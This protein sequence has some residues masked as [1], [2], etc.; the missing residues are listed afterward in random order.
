MPTLPIFDP[1]AFNNDFQPGEEAKEKAFRERW[2]GNL[3]R[4][5]EQTLLND[6]WSS[7]YQPALRDY[8]NPL[9]TD[10]PIAT[11]APITWTAFPRRI[12]TT[13]PNVGQ[14]KQ[15]QYADEGPPDPNYRPGGPRGWQDEYCEWSV[16]RRADG[17]IIRVSF[18]C[19]NREYWYTLWES[20]PEIVLRIY[21]QL[22]GSQVELEDFYLRD[23]NGQPIID[24]E[25]GRP[26]YDDTNKWNSTTTHGVVHL[27]S[28]PNSLSA[29][30]FLGGQATILRRDANGQPITDKNALINCSQYGTANRNSDPTIGAVVNSLVRGA[31]EPGSG[32]R[33]T[34]AN[35]VGLYI[36]EPSFDTYE[37]PFN[38]P[39]GAK[40]SD[41]WKI[42]RGRRRADGEVIDYIL[43]AVYEVP[44][45]HGFTVSDVTIGGFNVDF[46][47]QITQTF[48]IA[49]AGYPAP[50]LPP[51]P[52]SLLCAESAPEPLP[53]P[54]V[55]RDLNML[56]SAL[57]SSL[58]LRIEP[59]TR[60]E[61]VGL[62]AFDS[63]RD[64]RLEVSGA[65]GV[66]ATV[67]DF[68]ALQGAQLFILTLEVAADAALGNRGLQLINPDGAQ[69]P[70]VFGLIEVVA[71]G[72]LASPAQPAAA[73]RAVAVRPASVL[74]VIHRLGAGVQRGR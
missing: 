11:P 53:R 34:L 50:Q 58:N 33:I 47:S 42:V 13:F 73:V 55:L 12:Q 71:A 40:P 41:Y 22:V 15:W 37:L 8:F 25:T 27:I 60:V 1:P 30:I 21:R 65:P 18:T 51:P 74:D 24:R 6:P 28:N 5:T 61:N 14:R 70:P 17:K 64:A 62:Y 4:F 56:P 2:S 66:S 59:G 23:A 35:P 69:G 3:S 31:T 16:T 44:E 45:E 52:E 32:V 49:L 63:E 54:Y 38:A 9:T 10:V 29:E 7:L 72:T 68:Q 39:A 36:Q 26:A 48:Q 57:R 20:D 67:T 46:G 19:E 43:H